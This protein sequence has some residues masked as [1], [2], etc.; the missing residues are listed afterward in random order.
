MRNLPKVNEDII[1]DLLTR[2][3]ENP[4][5]HSLYTRSLYLRVAL[6]KQQTKN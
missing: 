5:S 2:Q 3:R 4:L 1:N 6:I